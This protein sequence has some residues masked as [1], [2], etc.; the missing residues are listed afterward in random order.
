MPPGGGRKFWLSDNIPNPLTESL[1][2]LGDGSR[3]EKEGEADK[4]GHQQ[5]KELSPVPAVGSVDAAA[6]DVEHQRGNDVAGQREQPLGHQSQKRH[7]ERYREE[8]HLEQKPHIEHLP[9]F[10]PLL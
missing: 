5:D 9:F 2:A 6:E 3:A 8:H 10:S 4:L 1:D 7:E